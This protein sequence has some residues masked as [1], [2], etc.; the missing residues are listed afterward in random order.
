MRGYFSLSGLYKLRGWIEE[1][2]RVY[3]QTKL[4][5]PRA[6]DVPVGLESAEPMESSL[7]PRH[8]Q[9]QTSFQQEEQSSRVCK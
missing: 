5:G 1:I 9:C 8:R 7:A 2:S 6:V 3:F 4:H